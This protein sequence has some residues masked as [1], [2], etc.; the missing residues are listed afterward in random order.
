MG[1]PQARMH[2]QLVG[3]RPLRHTH[4]SPPGSLAL[5]NYDFP[6]GAARRWAIYES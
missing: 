4:V 3:D 6:L 1:D 5:T 2:S